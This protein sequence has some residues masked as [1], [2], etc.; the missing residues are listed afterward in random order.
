MA[1]LASSST[2]TPACWIL[3]SRR[4]DY[5]AEWGGLLPGSFGSPSFFYLLLLELVHGSGRRLRRCR[6]PVR[7][8]IDSPR[9]SKAPPKFRPHRSR[10][11]HRSARSVRHAHCRR[12]APPCLLVR[13]GHRP[14][15]RLSTS[16]SRTLPASR[17]RPS[18]WAC[19]RPR[20]LASV[21]TRL[22][23]VPAAA[24]SQEIREAFLRACERRLAE[25]RK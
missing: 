20:S 4:P 21:S 19:N 6:L 12:P 2:S 25:L 13:W 3:N 16:R 24:A 15:P 23:S 9:R 10:Q 18:A 11:S 7:A 22:A 5:L 17:R 14:A 8:G 1:A